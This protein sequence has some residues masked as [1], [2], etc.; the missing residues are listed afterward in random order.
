[1]KRLKAT[2]QPRSGKPPRYTKP[3]VAIASRLQVPLHNQLK[4]EA[5]LAGRSISE[6][7]EYRLARGFSDQ[8]TTFDALDY[9]YGAENAALLTIFGEVIKLI[10]FWAP[11]LAAANEKTTNVKVTNMA[12]LDHPFLFE[13]VVKALGSLLE[14]LRPDG[15]A[16]VPEEHH[17]LL[18]F[19]PRTTKAMIELIDNLASPELGAA[20]SDWAMRARK[21]LSQATLAKIATAARKTSKL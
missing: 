3:R 21:K 14:V 9:I 17:E 20:R 8:R 16:I 13:E 5:E 18:G 19:G 4:L 6:E 12:W 2:A 7:I 15:E 1:M 11:A 10:G